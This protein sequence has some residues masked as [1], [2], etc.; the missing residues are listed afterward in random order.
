[1]IRR[2]RH[3]R[4]SWIEKDP[5][6]VIFKSRKGTVIKYSIDQFNTRVFLV[7]PPIKDIWFYL[8]HEPSK[9]DYITPGLSEITCVYNSLMRCKDK[10]AWRWFIRKVRD[11]YA[12][13]DKRVKDF[14]IGGTFLDFDALEKHEREVLSEYFS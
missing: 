7:F 10:Q 2:M 4:T 9:K 14:L 13:G 8:I 6:E 3:Y 12:G 1:M 11:L 5:T